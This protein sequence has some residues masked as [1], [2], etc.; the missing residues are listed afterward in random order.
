[1]RYKFNT[2]WDKQELKC[3]CLF[4]NSACDR[5]RSCEVLELTLKQYDDSKEYMNHSSYKRTHGAI[6]QRR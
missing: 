1:M 2:K 4:G 6:A 5:F 3:A